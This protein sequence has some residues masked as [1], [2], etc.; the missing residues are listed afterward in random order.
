[1][2]ALQKLGAPVALDER[3]NLQI[4]RRK[5]SGNAQFTSRSRLLSHGTMLIDSDLSRLEKLLQ[6]N[7]SRMFKSRATH[8]KPAS[9]AN[10]RPYLV[11]DLDLDDLQY[12]LI[13]TLLGDSPQR[14]S[15]S[16]EEWA[17]IEVLAGKKYRNF[18]WNIGQSPE[19]EVVVT[20]AAPGVRKMSLK[21]LF[22][23]GHF[24]QVSL[25]DRHL[26]FFEILMEGQPLKRETFNRLKQKIDGLNDPF[27]KEKAQRIF[28][29]W[30]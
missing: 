20:G 16:S 10:L 24:R 15:F 22:K 25:S 18:G 28:N 3:N 11:Q 12:I 13:K 14:V 21:Y 5:I 19:S 26:Q 9:V 27:L 2:Q 29:L 6:V 1:M 30:I 23:D 4:G 7:R 8:S 17:E